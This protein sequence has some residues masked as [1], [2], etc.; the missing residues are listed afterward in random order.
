MIEATGT[1]DKID[2]LLE[3]VRPYGV[4]EMVRTGRVEMARGVVPQG[5]NGRPVAAPGDDEAVGDVSNCSV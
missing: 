1:E 5:R 3:V 2:S 4:I